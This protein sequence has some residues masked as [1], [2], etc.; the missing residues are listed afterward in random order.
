MSCL[1]IQQYTSHAR[2][3]NRHIRPTTLDVV[4]QLEIFDSQDREIKEKESIPA[5]FRYYRYGE[6]FEYKCEMS[7]VR[8]V[9]PNDSSIGS[10]N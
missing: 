6:S 9:H 10:K 7:A 5:I 2:L 3:S 1:S 8:I 4:P